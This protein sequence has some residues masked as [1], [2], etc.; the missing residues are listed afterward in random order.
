MKIIYSKHFPPRPYMAI[1]LLK[2]IVVR[3]EA[4]DRFTAV[5]Y[6]HECIHY[7][8]EKE[9]LFVGFYILYVVDFLFTLLWFRNWHKAYRNVSFEREAYCHQEDLNYLQHRKRFAWAKFDY[10]L[11]D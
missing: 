7:A 6:N 1:T 9:L 3:S 8:Q 11:N 10:E 5:A 2:W 4:K